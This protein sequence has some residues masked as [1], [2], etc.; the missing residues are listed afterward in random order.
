[1]KKLSDY[2]HGLGLKI[3]IY[4]SPGPRTCGGY[5]GSYQHEEQDARMFA[6]WGID[7]LK[8]DWCSYSQIAPPNPDLNELKKPYVVMRAALDKNERDI[9]YSLCQYG[10]G[11]VWKWGEEVG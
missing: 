9:I 10:C 6:G 7:Y 4:S 11:E 3:G 8:Y 1:M 2:V 5:L